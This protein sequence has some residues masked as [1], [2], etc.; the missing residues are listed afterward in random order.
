MK[1]FFWSTDIRLLANS[2]CSR[3]SRS[4]GSKK[5]FSA[6]IFLAVGG[7]GRGCGFFVKINEVG[8]ME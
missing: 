8:I 5:T 2:S 3:R 4:Q 1:Q 6:K 7:K